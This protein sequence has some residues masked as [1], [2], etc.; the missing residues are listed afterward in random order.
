MASTSFNITPAI[1][2]K[3]YANTN[4]GIIQTDI[5]WTRYVSASPTNWGGACCLADKGEGSN[6]RIWVKSLDN[7]NNITNTAL[8]L[9]VKYV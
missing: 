3:T 4:T 7:F 1:K 8:I 6:V 5:P 9:Q 2:Y